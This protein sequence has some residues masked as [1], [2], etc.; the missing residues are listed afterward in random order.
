MFAL[1]IRAK[2]ADI[3]LA[4]FARGS[5]AW[6][7]AYQVFFAFKNKTSRLLR[8]NLLLKFSIQESCGYVSLMQL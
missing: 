7:L 4:G 8:I 3:G 5:V 1:E 6:E 2:L